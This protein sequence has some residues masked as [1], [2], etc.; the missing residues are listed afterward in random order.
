[1]SLA[2]SPSFPPGQSLRQCRTPLCGQ[3]GVRPRHP[4]PKRATG[5]AEISGRPD[6]QRPPGTVNFLRRPPAAAGRHAT[7][8]PVAQGIEQR[9]SNPP[10]GGSIPS[11]GTIF[12]DEARHPP[13]MGRVTVYTPVPG[14]GCFRWLEPAFPPPQFP[15]VPGRPRAPGAMNQEAGGPDSGSSFLRCPA[16]ETPPWDTFTCPVMLSRGQLTKIR[17]HIAAVSMRREFQALGHCS[18]PV[19]NPACAALPRAM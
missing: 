3:T 2:C 15:W 6:S 4:P 11:W 16:Q 10:V 17:G 13:R 9:P 7:R 14:P 8:A 18:W 19:R 12:C 1:M 5:T